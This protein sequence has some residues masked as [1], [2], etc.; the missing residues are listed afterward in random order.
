LITSGANLAAGCRADQRAVIAHHR[1]IIEDNIHQHLMLAFGIAITKQK[2]MARR[3]LGAPEIN[4]DAV[5][6]DMRLGNT[7]RTQPAPAIL[8]K[9]VVGHDLIT[10]LDLLDGLFRAICHIDWRASG[11]AETCIRFIVND[12]VNV[13]NFNLILRRGFTIESN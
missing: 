9:R 5:R 13:D 12:I 2:H 1:A 8:G 3:H 7:L 4:D 10:D 11:E 6:C